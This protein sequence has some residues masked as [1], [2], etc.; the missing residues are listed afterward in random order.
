ASDGELSRQEDQAAKDFER[1]FDLQLNGNPEEALPYLAR[2]S[3]YAPQN[4][5]Y[6][7]YY[8]KALAADESQ[9]HKA[10][11]ELSTAIRIEPQNDSF[12][13]MMAEFFIRYKLLKR[14]EGELSR[15]LAASPDNKQARA[16]L[17]SLAV[18]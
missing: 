8:G 13:L 2:A 11:N 4:A 10:E 12:R 5:R 3:H 6:H 15:L 17:D 18:K 7:A 14:A 16:L 9:R 1:G